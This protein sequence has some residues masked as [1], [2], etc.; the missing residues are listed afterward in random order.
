MLIAKVLFGAVVGGVFGFFLGRSKAC[1]TRG[2][3]ATVNLVF[4]I[5]ACAV[6]GAA[7]AYHF[8]TGG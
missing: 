7:V 2:C 3:N 8:G 6:A 1:S 5:L 4:S